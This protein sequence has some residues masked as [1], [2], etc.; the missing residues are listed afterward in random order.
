MVE[1]VM[2]NKQIILKHYVEGYPK[3]S[4]MEFKNNNIKLKQ[5]TRCGVA[6]VLKSGDSNFQEGVVVILVVEKI[7]HYRVLASKIST[8]SDDVL[9]RLFFERRPLPFTVVPTALTTAMNVNLSNASL[10]FISVTFATMISLTL[11]YDNAVAKVTEFEFWGFVFVM[12]AAVMSGF[13]WTMTQILLQVVFCDTRCI[14]I[15]DFL[16]HCFVNSMFAYFVYFL[17]VFP[18]PTGCAEHKTGIKKEAYG[19]KNPLTLMSYVTPVMTLST[20]VLSLIFDP[21][22]EFRH[23]NYFDTSWHIAR[24]CLLMLFGGTLAFFMVFVP[25]TSVVL[26]QNDCMTKLHKGST[27]E[28]E[29]GSPLGYAATKYVILEEMEDQDHGP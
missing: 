12:L 26:N 21:W 23:T 5:F 28:D 13:R 1:E 3:E 9:E 16:F 7:G 15:V 6:K 8:Y 19:L 4:D 22:H 20:A 11:F 24:S 2:N 14:V 29:T 10:V 27:S 18:Y 25:S 17:F